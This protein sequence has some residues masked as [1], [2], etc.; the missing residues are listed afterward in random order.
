MLKVI[1]QTQWTV[2]CVAYVLDMNIGRMQKSYFYSSG[3]I[4][5]EQWQVKGKAVSTPKGC[6]CSKQTAGLYFVFAKLMNTNHLKVFDH[7][8]IQWVAALEYWLPIQLGYFII[9][10]SVHSP[11]S[12]ATVK[13]ISSLTNPYALLLDSFSIGFCDKWLY[14]LRI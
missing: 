1:Q 9:K 12:S 14:L 4:P 3:E 5:E 10:H 8:Q 11:F 2:L 6:F 13:S 7:S